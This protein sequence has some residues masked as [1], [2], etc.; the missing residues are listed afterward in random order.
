MVTKSLGPA[1]DG[2]TVEIAVQT[3]LNGRAVIHPRS[4]RSL[5]APELNRAAASRLACSSAAY[6]CMSPTGDLPRSL[7]RD[8]K[9]ASIVCVTQSI[10][11]KSFMLHSSRASMVDSDSAHCRCVPPYRRHR[12]RI[13]KKTLATAPARCSSTAKH[14][15]CEIQPTQQLEASVP[16]TII[17]SC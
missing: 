4:I 14:E 10:R 7:N 1:Y 15:T 5:S 9:H 8:I 16:S 12:H 3:W 17:I 13:T 6:N 2:T 11:A